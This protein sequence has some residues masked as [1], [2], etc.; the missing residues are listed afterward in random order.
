[1][2]Q[3]DYLDISQSSRSRK[4][5]AMKETCFFYVSTYNLVTSEK[6]IVLY[7][8]CMSLN[9]ILKAELF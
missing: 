6:N 9:S 5:G 3:I 1:M 8:L 7:D 4:C 2:M